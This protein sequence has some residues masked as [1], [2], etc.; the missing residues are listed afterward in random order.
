[1]LR[2]SPYPEG[3]DMENNSKATAATQQRAY[4]A[5]LEKGVDF[6]VELARPNWLHRIGLLPKVRK[7]VIKPLYLGTLFRVTK[8]ILEIDT[9]VLK[10]A[11]GNLHAIGVES[12]A[13]HKDGLVRIVAL[14]VTNGDREP[15]KRLVRFLDRN[16]TPKD[17]LRL[18]MLVVQQMEVRDFLACMV[19]IRQI[20]LSG[21]GKKETGQTPRTSGSPSDA[22]SSITDSVG[23]TYCGA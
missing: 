19:S 4:D 7:F 14:A 17:L 3:C 21:A 12:I 15:P 18:V 8:L 16:L 20:S 13:R 23:E 2:P 6:D 5:I 10:E 11:D 9:D 1:M 22:S